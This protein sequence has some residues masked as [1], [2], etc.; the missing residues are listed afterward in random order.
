[1]K[2]AD[3]KEGVFLFY[4]EITKGLEIHNTFNKTYIS[5][6]GNSIKNMKEINKPL[7]LTVKNVYAIMIITPDTIPL[8]K[9]INTYGKEGYHMY[10]YEWKPQSEANIKV[11]NHLFDTIQKLTNLIKPYL[12]G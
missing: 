11:L 2:I 10:K 1:M 4:P 8:E 9:S 6:R 7:I 12:N 3:F 5:I